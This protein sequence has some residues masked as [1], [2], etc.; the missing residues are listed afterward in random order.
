MA[1][2][3]SD[4]RQD[5]PPPAPEIVE[6]VADRA[7]RLRMRGGT[8]QSDNAHAPIERDRLRAALAR[9]VDGAADR[10]PSDQA[11]IVA[12]NVLRG[13]ERAIAAADRGESGT[14]TGREFASLEAIVRVLGRPAMRYTNNRVEMPLSDLGENDQWRVLVAIARSK[15]DK[16]S[17]SVGR[18]GS[19]APYEFVGT[20]WR[21][22][23]DLLVTNRHVATKMAE[24]STAP[25]GSWRIGAGRW[26]V[27][28]NVTDSAAATRPV[29]IKELAY[30]AP[31]EDIDFA[32]LR[33]DTGAG[34]PDA[35]PLDWSADALG[36]LNET[37]FSGAEVYI[38]GH[39]FRQLASAESA[40]VFGKADG[41]KRCSPG[42]VVRVD[43]PTYGFE[44]DCSTLGGNSGSCVLTASGHQVVGLH[45][46]GRDVDEGTGR[47]AG[48]L[49][50]ALSRLASHRAGDIL[51]NGRV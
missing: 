24:N 9:E 37:T 10:E 33:L 29:E 47:G 48:N 2:E 36:A 31:E 17:A 14:I 6:R 5:E 7:R 3:P 32:V 46:G 21:I 51:K 45:Y 40:A 38:V 50:L 1:H 26:F 23:P 39:P 13:A 34:V 18:I 12:D 43:A 28:F 42:F 15:I 27:S 20:G 22:G 16:R 30:T 35:L 8:L 49:A 19:A 44:H 11:W 41:T 4:H 25:S